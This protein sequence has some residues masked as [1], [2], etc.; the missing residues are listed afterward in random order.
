M[1]TPMNVRLDH[2][3][4]QRA[5]IHW[6]AAIEGA[7]G[8][9]SIELA[10]GRSVDVLMPDFLFSDVVQTAD[11]EELRGV[12]LRQKERIVELEQAQEAQLIPG[13]ELDAA[14]VQEQ[15]A[16]LQD[17][18]S[19][20]AAADSILSAVRG[21]TEHKL[22]NMKIAELE[23]IQRD[24]GLPPEGNRAERV[25]SIMQRFDNGQMEEKTEIFQKTLN[26]GSK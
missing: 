11:E 17:A 10:F 26:A 18:N 6:Y 12:I 16:L 7:Q 9:G 25:E 13:D 21:V 23:K 4:P 2:C 20:A 19:K 22:S 5:I 24:V 8:E 1:A 15:D 3:D 14:R